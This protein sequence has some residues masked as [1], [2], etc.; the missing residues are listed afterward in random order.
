MNDFLCGRVLFLSSSLQTPTSSALK[1]F[2]TMWAFIKISDSFPVKLKIFPSEMSN[3]DF[4]GSVHWQPCL[5]LVPAA[6]HHP[7]QSLKRQ[8]GKASISEP[9]AESGA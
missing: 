6:S 1:C 3:S 9:N 5:S 2:H 8:V 4:E 7:H